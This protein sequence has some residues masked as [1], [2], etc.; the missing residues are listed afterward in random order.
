MINWQ[1]PYAAT[2]ISNDGK[3]L[4]LKIPEFI[5]FTDVDMYPKRYWFTRGAL[6][7]KSLI[8]EDIERQKDILIAK[9]TKLRLGGII[10]VSFTFGH[11]SA[12]PDEV[13]NWIDIKVDNLFKV[14]K[15]LH[16]TETN[17]LELITERI[18]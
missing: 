12:K 3:T 17:E 14:T 7:I 16:H 18:R 9:N 4:Y 5:D 15:I 13:E 2:G 1:I 10:K 6:H 11:N 8:I